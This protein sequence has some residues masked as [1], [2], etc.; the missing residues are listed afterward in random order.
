MNGPAT[1]QLQFDFRTGLPT[2]FTGE[3]ASPAQCQA[4]ATLNRSRIRGI[5]EAT[6]P[7]PSG[8]PFEADGWHAAVAAKS[9]EWGVPLIPLERFGFVPEDDSFAF[10]ASDDLSII[11][12]GAEAYAY[13]DARQRCVYKFFHLLPNAA[14]G[15]RLVLQRESDGHWRA[16]KIDGNLEVTLEKLAVLHEAG[17]CPTEI[18]GLA[19]TGDFLIVKQPLCQPYTDWAAD[20]AEAVERLKAV[21]SR[22]SLGHGIRLFWV[23]DQLWC[24][25]DLHTGNVMRLATGEPVIIDALIAP[26]PPVVLQECPS[27]NNAL[28][29]AKALR[30]GRE[31]PPEDISS[32]VHDDDL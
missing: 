15:K 20:E 17:G 32:G 7:A 30:L 1:S 24:V 31:F 3:L 4:C 18:V 21:S 14:L 13:Q 12:W 22:P 2:A 19:Q 26:V 10:K 5:K 25:G 27:L 16:G 29:R 28:L 6:K 11:G 23:N 8:E 9:I